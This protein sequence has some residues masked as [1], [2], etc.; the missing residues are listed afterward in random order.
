MRRKRDG[1]GE[2]VVD[3][4]EGGGGNVGEGGLDVE[5]VE[6]DDVGSGNAV[7]LSGVDE[8]FNPAGGA[9]YVALVM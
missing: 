8:G 4:P 7:L 2:D 5:D 6:A 3:G 9:V 1:V